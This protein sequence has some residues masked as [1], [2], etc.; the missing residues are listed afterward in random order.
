MATMNKHWKQL[1][2]ENE[3]IHI[4][5]QSHHKPCVIFKD[6]TTCGISASAKHKIH[7]DFDKIK[8]NVEFYYLDLLQYRS[9]SNLIAEQLNVIHQSPQIIVLKNG[10][11]IHHSSHYAI[12]VDKI[13]ETIL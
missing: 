5:K 10:K 8:E 2:T 12:S 4:I 6:S 1:I 13:A 9:I 3:F 7:S 11:V